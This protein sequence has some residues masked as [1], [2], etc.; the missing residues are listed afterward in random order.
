MGDPWG[1]SLARRLER[2]AL[3]VL[4][5]HGHARSRVIVNKDAQGILV[6]IQI[7]QGPARVKKVVLRLG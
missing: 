4:S 1:P 7:P 5:R 2:E 3:S 6:Q